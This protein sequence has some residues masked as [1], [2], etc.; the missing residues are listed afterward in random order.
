MS[1]SADSSISPA[2]IVCK[3]VKL[4]ELW[5][6]EVHCGPL[7]PQLAAVDPEALPEPLLAM[8]KE[9]KKLPKWVFD[10]NSDFYRRFKLVGRRISMPKFIARPD[11][12]AEEPSDPITAELLVHALPHVVFI[13]NQHR[14]LLKPGDA[15]FV[16]ETSLRIPIDRLTSHV[17]EEELET[18]RF[19]AR[20]DCRLRLPSTE[21][22]QI[23][24]CT[25]GSVAFFCSPSLPIEMFSSE[26]REGLVCTSAEPQLLEYVHWVTDYRQADMA[27]VCR[28]VCYGMVSSLWQRRALGRMNDFV[29]GTGLAGHSLTVYAAQWETMEWLTEPGDVSSPNVAAEANRTTLDEPGSSEPTR[30]G[31][32][33]SQSRSAS[34][35]KTET[36]PWKINSQAGDPRERHQI[37]I[38][39]IGE[40]TTLDAVQMTEYYLLLRASIGMANGYLGEVL[41]DTGLA[42]KVKAHAKAFGWPFPPKPTTKSH[43]NSASRQDTEFIS[44]ELDASGSYQAPCVADPV[45]EAT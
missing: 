25:A 32:T 23:D 14:K 29:F 33:I 13:S 34:A 6:N 22:V 4:F 12:N 20:L 42:E 31:P 30:V 15:H 45:K 39:K 8:V 9:S 1:E 28:K 43:T 26:L 10:E 3:N 11:T 41:S 19:I 5:A 38:Y 24:G 7:P 17:C 16:N 27:E 2:S 44:E 36:T 35:K 40:Y 18:D 21:A 37:K